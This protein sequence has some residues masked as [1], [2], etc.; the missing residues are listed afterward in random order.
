MEECV[1]SVS[2][3]DALESG[4][5]SAFEFAELVRDIQPN[6]SGFSDSQMQVISKREDKALDDGSLLI[7]NFGHNPL[8]VMNTLVQKSKYCRLVISAKL[9]ESECTTQK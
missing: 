7:E 4:K 2:E 8:N 1:S 5:I 9:R 6:Y 3:V